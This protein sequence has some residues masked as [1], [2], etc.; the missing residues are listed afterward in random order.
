VKSHQRIDSQDAKFCPSL[1]NLSG[2]S[3]TTSSAQNSPRVL[4]PRAF[5]GANLAK[6][7]NLGP[8]SPRVGA[9]R[10]P[11]P[12]QFR[13]SAAETSALTQAPLANCAFV[14]LKAEAGYALFLFFF[15]SFLFIY[16]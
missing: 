3:S 11:I 14:V 6:D 15:F 16:T 7:L 5:A 10:S 13:E 1:A 4:S 9:K 12:M 2:V 8:N